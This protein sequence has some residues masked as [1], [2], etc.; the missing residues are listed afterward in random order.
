MNMKIIK[1]HNPRAENFKLIE[2]SLH[3]VC[4]YD[5]G[6]CNHVSKGGNYRWL[7]NSVYLNAIDKF[8][9][10]AELENKKIYFMFTGGEP[11]LIPDFLDLLKHVKNRGHFTNLLTNGSRTLRWWQEA[12]DANCID[13]MWLSHHTEQGADVNLTVSIVE[14]FKD[15]PTNIC[16][17]VTAPPSHFDESYR[18]HQYIVDNAV[19]T[20]SFRYI[21]LPQ[22]TLYNYTPEQLEILQKNTSVR[23]KRF[24]QEKKFHWIP[25]PWEKINLVFEDGTER[26]DHPTTYVSR[27]EANF[28][29]WQCSTGRD[30][31]RIEHTNIYRG[32]CKQD[33]KIGDILD[34]NFGFATT[35]TTCTIPRCNCIADFNQP[36]IKKVL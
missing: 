19:C 27:G 8:I 33:G 17:I 32:T 12:A 13:N 25:F 11:T 20:S 28:F 10:Q 15:L 7:D 30:F 6:F 5:C 9:D 23:S 18:N 4:N 35:D 1:I 29:G 36:K 24:E 34:E 3:N 26:I 22:S 21:Y 16:T 31:L 14:L 2:W